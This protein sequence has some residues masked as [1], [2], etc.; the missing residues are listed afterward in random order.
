M[1]KIEAKEVLDR[2][3]D[4]FDVEDAIESL[5]ILNKLTK[6]EQQIENGE[7]YTHEE[8]KKEVNSWFK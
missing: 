3:P 4:E 6:A 7:F 8:V 5:I 1:L 2:L